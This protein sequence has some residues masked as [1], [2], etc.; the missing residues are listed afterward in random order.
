MPLYRPTRWCRQLCSPTGAVN[1]VSSEDL[2]QAEPSQASTWERMRST[3]AALNFIISKQEHN[4]LIPFMH[5][6]QDPNR[7]PTPLNV[8]PYRYTN[9]WPCICRRQGSKRCRAMLP[10][11]NAT[12]W[13]ASV[14]RAHVV[15]AYMSMDKYHTYS[16]V[17]TFGT[18]YLMWRDWDMIQYSRGN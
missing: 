2:V 14:Q 5:I 13:H 16:S 4:R 11:C 3:R 7:D 10:C 17:L 12:H 15:Q 6:I 8:W 1:Y 9:H 18:L